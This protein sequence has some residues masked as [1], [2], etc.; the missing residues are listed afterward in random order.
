MLI[1]LSRIFSGCRHPLPH[2]DDVWFAEIFFCLHVC[3]QEDVTAA[4]WVMLYVLPELC[5]RHTTYVWKGERESLSFVARFLGV[6]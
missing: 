1:Y 3:M 2:P 4:V 5:H 6:S